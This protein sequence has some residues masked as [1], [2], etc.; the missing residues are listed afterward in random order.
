LK[1]IVVLVDEYDKPIVTHLGNGEA[2]LQTA[3]ENR[4][5]VKKFSA[6]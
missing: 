3:R 1:K 6:C 2:G 4:D 5:V